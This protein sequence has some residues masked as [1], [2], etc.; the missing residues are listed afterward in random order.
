MSL[1][2]I[3]LLWRLISVRVRSVLI[4]VSRLS[5]LPI[6]RPAALPTVPRVAVFGSRTPALFSTGFLAVLSEP[7]VRPIR[8]GGSACGERTLFVAGCLFVFETAGSLLPITV[9]MSRLRFTLRSPMEER[10]D[11]RLF[12]IPGVV[13]G[14][15]ELTAGCFAFVGAEE[16]R[17][18]IIL[19]IREFLLERAAGWLALLGTDGLVVLI[20]LPIREVM[21]GLIR[22]LVLVVDL[23][24]IVFRD[25]LLD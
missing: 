15:L 19:P 11:E 4:R 9:P 12:L 16:L 10:S 5:V 3:S 23:F 6:V 24:V 13:E 17:V 7:I 25:L 2:L 8:D 20:V 1:I 22:L 14:L 21:L 18:P